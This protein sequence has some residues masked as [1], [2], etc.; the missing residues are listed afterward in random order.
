MISNP[1]VHTGD[2]C[3]KKT[4]IQNVARLAGN[5]IDEEFDPIAVT[6]GGPEMTVQFTAEDALAIASDPTL[7]EF[8]CPSSKTGCRKA[9]KLLLLLPELGRHKVV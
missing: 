1:E 4:F 8:Y 5:L 2:S 9:E 6:F 7:C 3:Q